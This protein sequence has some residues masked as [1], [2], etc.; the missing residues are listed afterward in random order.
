LLNELGHPAA[1]NSE[2]YFRDEFDRVSGYQRNWNTA[3][4]N[5]EEAVQVLAGFGVNASVD[6]GLSV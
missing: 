6:S 1:N 2:Q 4:A 3:G 5:M